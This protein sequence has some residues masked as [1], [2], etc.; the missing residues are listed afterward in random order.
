MDAK[1]WQI[2]KGWLA[3]LADLSVAERAAYLLLHNTDP[4]L[5]EQVLAI[6]EDQVSVSRIVQSAALALGTQI[7]PYEI[8]EAIGAGAMSEVYRAK[9]HKLGRDVAIKV[10]PVVFAG[11]RDR[12]ARF[13]REAQLLASLNHPHITQ[14]YGVEEGDGHR[15]LVME[16]VEGETLADRVR[17]GPVPLADALPIA[18]QVAEALEAAH[19]H[20]IIHRDLKPANIKVRSD[21]TVKVLDFGLAKVVDP[22]GTS[23]AVNSQALSAGAT[24][25]GLILGTPAYMSPEQAC[26][27]PVDRRTDLW[28]FGVV[29]M[30]MLTGRRAFWRDSVSHVLAAVLTAE[31]DWSTLPPA[32]PAGIER[33]LRRCLQKDSRKRIDSAAVAAFE[34]DD[35]SSGVPEAQTDR[36]SLREAGRGPINP[37]RDGNRDPEPAEKTSR[38][39]KP[40][41]ADVT[42]YDL[43]LR[44]IL[45]AAM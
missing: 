21:G 32:T 31:P 41:A 38:I 35:A 39:Y 44:R 22:I 30:E 25:D 37:S 6:L 36:Q 8:V 23:N 27:K 2:V 24:A 43:N 10:L 1:T 40:D 15:A 45:E 34:I 14:L 11:N 17:R 7:G 18:R 26:G 19:D 13:E 42:K 4:A 5:H 3:D 28:A 16:L 20:G 29:L 12:L 9:D 33:L